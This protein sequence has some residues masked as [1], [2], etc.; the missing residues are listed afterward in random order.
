MT[1]RI[2]ITGNLGKDPELK[3]S[4]AGTPWVRFSVGATP[5][6]QN[7][8]TQEW[9]NDGA[10]QWYVVKVFGDE[11][12]TVAETLRKGDRVRVSGSLVLEPWQDGS[13]TDMVIKNPQVSIIPRTGSNVRSGSQGYQGDP[14]NAPAASTATNSGN[15]WGTTSPGAAPF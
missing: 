12:E 10:D 11:A 14:G 9:E 5:R 2:D 13:R 8:Q 6:V 1:A 3:Y 7:R 4:Q 15:P